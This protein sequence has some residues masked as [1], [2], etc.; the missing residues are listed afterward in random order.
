MR[1]AALLTI[2]FLIASC[3]SPKV[4]YQTG[5]SNTTQAEHKGPGI[6]LGADAPDAA[7][8][9]RDG[10]PV[11]LAS[12][13]PDGPTIII[14]YRGG[15]C[16]YCNLTLAEWAKRSDE[17]A[18]AGANVIALSPEKPSHA[19]ETADSHD[20]GVTI[21]SDAQH[22]AARGFDVL[23]ELGALD[24]AGYSLGGIQLDEW[25]E[26][27]EWALPYSATFVV[28]RNG[29][30]VY[31]YASKDHTKRADPEDVLAAIRNLE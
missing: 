17:V 25:N 30:V 31:R 15:W 9:D 2:P 8:L 21:Y 18:A 14:F 26:S 24:R 12:L 28:D 3:G 22:E 1:I 27:G 6:A 16:T 13:Y 10:S 23:D 5:E 4:N 20:D 11:A 29:T 7:L 19:D